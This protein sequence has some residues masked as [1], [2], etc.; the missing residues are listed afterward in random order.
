MPWYYLTDKDQQV[1]FDLDDAPNLIQGGVLSAQTLV[2]TEGMAEWLPAHDGLPDELRAFFPS[3]EEPLPV[4]Q[5]LPGAGAG[6]AAAAAPA[7]AS[8]M[9]RRGGAAP[10]A[11]NDPAAA[12]R[13]AEIAAAQKS[14]AAADA[15]MVRDLTRPLTTAAGWMKVIGV[16]LIVNGIITAVAPAVILLMIAAKFPLAAGIGIAVTL[17]F[18]IFQ[19][20]AGANAFSA[21]GDAQNAAATGHRQ[22]ALQ[23]FSKLKR[24][25]TLVGVQILLVLGILVVGAVGV[26]MQWQ[27]FQNMFANLQSAQAGD[28]PGMAEEPQDN[29]PPAPEQPK[30]PLP[31]DGADD[32]S[33]PSDPDTEA[34]GADAGA[35]GESAGGDADPT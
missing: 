19:I 29:P 27:Q 5:A 34:G 30:F 18:G 12:Q 26:W 24:F 2:W 25:W 9:L 4:A 16:A 31:S 17:P 28:A 22:I 32:G 3:P 6:M 10:A 23:M 20:W 8:P 13:A 35:A 11:A 33:D 21:G 1:P 14:L 7:L 15:A